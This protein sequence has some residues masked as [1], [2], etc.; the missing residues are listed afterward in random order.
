MTFRTMVSRRN[1]VKKKT[2]SLKFIVFCIIF[3]QDFLL[4]LIIERFKK[5]KEELKKNSESQKLSSRTLEL[6]K[7]RF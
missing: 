2:L 1:F 3:Y 5:R 6:N 7:D 4:K